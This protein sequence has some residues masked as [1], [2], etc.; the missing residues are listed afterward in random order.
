MRHYEIVF[1]VHPDQSEQVPAMIE[2]Y[3]EMVTSSGANFDRDEF[4]TMR[5]AAKK[6]YTNR[7]GIYSDGPGRCEERPVDFRRRVRAR[8]G[9][10]RPEHAGQPDQRATMWGCPPGRKMASQ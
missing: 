1:L 8:D 5:E 10:D 2:R 3:S 9:A 4:E 7:R 6:A